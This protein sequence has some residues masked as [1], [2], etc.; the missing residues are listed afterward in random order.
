MEPKPGVAKIGSTIICGV[1]NPYPRTIA[2]T[3]ETPA[4][5]AYANNL[6]RSKGGSWRLVEMSKLDSCVRTKEPVIAAPLVQRGAMPHYD[7]TDEP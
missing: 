1:R 5:V 2:M 4:A 7:G 6:L 3:L